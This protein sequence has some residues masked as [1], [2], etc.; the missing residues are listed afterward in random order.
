MEAKQRIIQESVPGKQLTLAHAIANPDASLYQAAGLTAATTPEGVRTGAIGIL[1]LT[2]GES[3]LIAGDIAVK[4][5]GVSVGFLDLERGTL[6]LLGGLS[7]IESALG[8]V[9]DYVRDRLHFEVCEITR[10]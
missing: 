10:T 8:A 2:P 9:R 7:A 3:A 1:T 5:S 6:I 4:A